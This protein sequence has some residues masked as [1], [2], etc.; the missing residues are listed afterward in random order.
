LRSNTRV[1]RRC[2]LTVG[3]FSIFLALAGT[4]TAQTGGSTAPGGTA[5]PAPTVPGARAKLKSNGKA[6]APAG[7][8]QQIIDA[9]A[10]GNRIRKKPYVWGGGHK[11]FES[12]GYDCSGAVS[13]VLNAAGLLS[14]PMPSGPLMSW[15]EEGKG[16]WITVFANGGHAYMVVAG[17][18]FDTSAMGSGGNGPRWRATKRS[19]KGFA[20]RHAAGL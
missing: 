19:P 13:Y 17:L 5:P 3:V 1:L 7:A 8:P 16:G 20:V 2:L 12:N 18:R 11:S 6:I 9:I 15:G 10:A 4:A 14:S